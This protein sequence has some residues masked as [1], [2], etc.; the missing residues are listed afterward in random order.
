MGLRS[1]PIVLTVFV[2]VPTGDQQR[3]ENQA[4]HWWKEPIYRWTLVEQISLGDVEP[5][6]HAVEAHGESLSTAA[7]HAI[8]G[9]A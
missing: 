3:R 2:S 1:Q 4:G 8:T 6:W 5:D 9:V 7:H